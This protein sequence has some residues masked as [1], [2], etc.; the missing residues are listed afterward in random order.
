MSRSYKK[1]A[2]RTYKWKLL[3]KQFFR[4]KNRCMNKTFMHHNK[5]DKLI[6]NPKHYIK[7]YENHKNRFYLY[8]HSLK[9]NKPIHCHCFNY[10]LTNG[11][12]TY[13]IYEDYSCRSLAIRS[14]MNI[15]RKFF[16]K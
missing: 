2:A 4:K 3:E 5:Y 10:T 12:N 11:K 16:M 1:N 6:D 13:I 14:K 9:M 7:P 8:S 15:Y